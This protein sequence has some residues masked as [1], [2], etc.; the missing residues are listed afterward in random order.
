MCI[1][2][3]E[4]TRVRRNFPEFLR[5]AMC[6]KALQFL[7]F[8]PAQFERLC[9]LRGSL[10]G[11]SRPARQQVRFLRC[12]SSVLEWLQTLIFIPL[13]SSCNCSVGTDR[14]RRYTEDQLPNILHGQS[15]HEKQPVVLILVVK[16]PGTSLSS[17]RVRRCG[18]SVPFHCAHIIRW[19]MTC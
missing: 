9:D 13:E 15:V 12:R 7:V 19:F 11:S 6:V 4:S 3:K 1:T 2:G 5:K 16:H 17:H 10:H 14:R 8:D 18:P